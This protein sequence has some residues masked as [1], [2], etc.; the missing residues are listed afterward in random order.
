MSP[1][2]TVAA[3]TTLGATLLGVGV[4]AGVACGPRALSSS[5]IETPPSANRPRVD[6]IARSGDISR[7]AILSV[8]PVAA[9]NDRFLASLRCAA[10]A[11]SMQVGGLGPAR[12]ARS[13]D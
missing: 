6:R 1:R 7:G 10:L 5:A 9:P 8:D 11:H 12:V 13:V 3:A 2:V 4:V